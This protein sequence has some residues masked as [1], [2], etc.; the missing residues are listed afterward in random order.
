[1][2]KTI[3][4]HN[5]FIKLSSLVIG[6]CAWLFIA[7]H[8]HITRTQQAPLCFYQADTNYS[9]TA[10]ENIKVVLSGPRDEIYRFNSTLH[11]DTSSYQEGSHLVELTKENLFLPDN[12]K[13]LN[14][15]PSHVSIN[16]SKT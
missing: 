8:Q 5:H 16:V 15:I 14:L 1:M 7:Q 6:Y 9:I 12:I 13:L 2:I 11:I 3:M 10:P 4:Q